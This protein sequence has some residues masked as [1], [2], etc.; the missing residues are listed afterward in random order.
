MYGCKCGCGH[1]P[2]SVPRAGARGAGAV[3]P[4]TPHQLALASYPSNIVHHPF[5]HSFN[6]HVLAI[7]YIN[8]GN[9]KDEWDMTLSLRTKILTFF[10]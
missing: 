9:E 10:P 7:Y 4:Q 6:T 8:A 1:E 2:A 3:S 5:I